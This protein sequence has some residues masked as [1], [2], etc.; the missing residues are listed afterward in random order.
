MLKGE[1]TLLGGG[2]FLQF[3]NGT[4]LVDFTHVGKYLGRHL[5]MPTNLIDRAKMIYVFFL[6]Y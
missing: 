4:T 2:L 6:I 3:E 5:K 1:N